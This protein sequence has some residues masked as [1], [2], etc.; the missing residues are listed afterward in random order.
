MQ[1][2]LFYDIETTGLNKAFDQ[3]LQFAAIRTDLELQELERYEFKVKLNP[4]VTPSPYALLTHQ[5]SITDTQAGISE[6]TAIQHIHQIM[7]EPGTISIGYNTL[8]FDDEFLRFAFYR[9]LLPPYTH[10]YANQC[11]RVDLYPI[12]IMYHLFKKDILQWPLIEGETKL[13]LEL[14]NLTNNLVQGRAHD[15]M[16]DVEITLAVAKRFM[17]AREM[18]DYVTRYFTKQIDETRSYALPIG[19]ATTQGNYQES[20]MVLGRIGATNYF[21]A[22]V[23][24]LGNHTTYRNQ[25][26]LRL[27]DE[28]LITTTADNIADTTWVYRKKWGEPG[29]VLPPKERFLNYLTADR[30]ALAEKNKAWLQQHPAILKQIADYHKN[31]LYPVLP[32]TDIDA[33][34]YLNAFWTND[35]NAFCQRFHRAG[36]TEK[37]SLI[38]NIKNPKLRELAV[39]L[40]GRNYPDL[41]T[42]ALQ[43][44]FTDYLRRV[45]SADPSDAMID[46]KGHPRLTPQA[47]L[48]EIK[49]LREKPLVLAHTE[50]LNELESY[51]LAKLQTPADISVLPL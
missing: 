24:L 18:W 6:Y 30:R 26:W 32:N 42:A 3:V 35:E 11:A 15:A 25:A 7:N 1:T 8:G 49:T 38:A 28:K 37:V 21:Q 20:L 22:P 44:E 43:Q 4:D 36:L 46:F 40:M 17:A 13:K 51:L 14:I 48:A 19:A 34:L 47:A 39:R 5:I 12:T 50:L 10:Q 16:V 45:N 33:S 23:L 2:Y 29:F 27:D 41:L 31:F 9:N